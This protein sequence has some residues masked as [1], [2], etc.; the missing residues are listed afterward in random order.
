M[1][2]RTQKNVLITAK[3][4]NVSNRA[5]YEAY[6]AKKDAMAGG[7]KL[8]A[9]ELKGRIPRGKTIPSLYHLFDQ[10]IQLTDGSVIKRVSQ[11]PK[12]SI[13]SLLDQR[14]NIVYNPLRP[15]LA[16]KKVQSS[17]VDKFKQKFAAT[18]SISKKSFSVIDP[19]SKEEITVSVE[20]D[21]EESVVADAKPAGDSAASLDGE[22]DY[23]EMDDFLDLLDTTD[24]TGEVAKG[25]ILQNEVVLK[26]GKKGKK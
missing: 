6:L 2:S 7:S 10:Y 26:K 14:A 24:A 4:F 5:K 15:D 23:G 21:V 16:Q 8:P 1:L 20:N 9:Y 25:G 19:D 18:S 3:R 12:K 11:Y 17:T 22:F 13:I